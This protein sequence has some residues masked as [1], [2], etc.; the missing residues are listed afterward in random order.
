MSVCMLLCQSIDMRYQN[1]QIH[2][3]LF[4]EMVSHSSTIR[5][6]IIRIV[7]ILLK[8]KVMEIRINRSVMK[9]KN[10]MKKINSQRILWHFIG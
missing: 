4:Y 5:I 10:Q 9:N 1:N 2:T 8:R 7:I 3:N 6:I